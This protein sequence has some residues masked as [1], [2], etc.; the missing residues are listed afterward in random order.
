MTRSL[1]VALAPRGIRV[2]AVAFGSVMSASLR[3]A[4]GPRRI[5]EDITGGTPMGRIAPPGTECR[6]SVPRLGCVQAS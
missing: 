2:N 5:R 3:A 6:R 4:Q 1:A